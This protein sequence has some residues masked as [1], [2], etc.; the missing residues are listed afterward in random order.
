MGAVLNRALTDSP[1]TRAA[2]AAVDELASDIVELT[3]ALV[4]IP[5]ETCPPH[6]NEGPG[7]RYLDAYL[8]EQLSW[9]TDVFLPTDVRGIEQHPGWWPG[10]DYTDRPNVV[11]LRKGTGGGRSVILNG[12]IDVVAAGNPALWRHEPYSGVIEDG[13]IYGRGSVD[14]KGG[15]ASMIMAVHAIERAGIRLRGDVIVESVVNEELG[16]YNGTLGCIAR[17]YE[18]DAAVVTEGTLCRIMPAHKGGVGLRLRVPGLGAHANLWWRGVSALDKALVLKRTLAGLQAERA[19][20]LRSNPYFSDSK[21]FPVPALVDTVWSLS[22]GHP[23][24]MSPPQEAVLDFWL[25]AL[26]GESLEDVIEEL[27][28]R[29]EAAADADP[30]LA[31][32]R[33]VLERHTAMRSFHPTAVPLDH[34]FIAALEDGCRVVDGLEPRVIGLS[35]VCDAM[36]FNLYSSTPAVVFGP[37]DLAV[38]HGPDEYI[39]IDQLIRAA[40]ILALTIVDWCGTS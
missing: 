5:T 19:V 17:G 28:R 8:R 39:E 30:F 22:A 35:S 15:I 36:M 38:A 27:S 21:E 32:H 7:Q 10:L 13:R 18:A 14:M 6:G 2:T 25:D 40:K 34:P 16:G 26:P 4:R 11:A 23:D 29:L 3:R 31:E 12:H 20:Q 9:E 37:G 33:P 24:V 1:E